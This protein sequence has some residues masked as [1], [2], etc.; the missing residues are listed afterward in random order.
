MY[1]A[2]SNL[3]KIKP[4]GPF[5]VYLKKLLSDDELGTI[6]FYFYAK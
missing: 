4:N 1:I 3:E 5:R 6:H 2:S